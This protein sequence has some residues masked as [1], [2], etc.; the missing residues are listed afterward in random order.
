MKS[1]KFVFFSLKILGDK[2]QSEQSKRKTKKSE[3]KQRKWKW[4]KAILPGIVDRK[5][6]AQKDKNETLM[7]IEGDEAYFHLHFFFPASINLS[8][9]N[10]FRQLAILRIE[11]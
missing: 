6:G 1:N 3:K 10:Q 7:T 9:T 8:R 5:I 4:T 11:N 2:K